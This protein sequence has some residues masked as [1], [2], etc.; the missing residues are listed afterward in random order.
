M[1][2][3]TC[4]KPIA[5]MLV[6]ALGALTAET[7]VA[8]CAAEATVADVRE[9]YAR[10]QQREQAGDAR[11]ALGAYVSAQQYTCD[12]NP[13]DAD[14]ARRAAR[15]ALPL[16]A[17]AKARGDH[18]GAFE[19]LE[20]GGHFAAAD[21]ALLAWIAAQPD[22]LA[23][24]ARARQHF[25]YRA[26]PAFQENEELRLSLL[27][28]YKVDP[29]H[30][31]LV[32][33]M[34][35]RGVERALADE[36]AA[37]DEQYLNGY[38]ELI[39]SRPEN[40]TDIAALQQFTVHA[41]AFHARHGRDALRESLQALQRAQAW[42]READPKVAAGLG[43]YRVERAASRAAL[44]TEKFADTPAL[45]ERALDYLAHGTGDTAA[46]ESALVRVRQQAEALG[47]GA[48]A[49]QSFQLAIEFYGIARADAKADRLQAQ[50]QVL[51]QQQMQ[52]SIAAM[53][54]DAT[55]LM[56]QFADPQ[57]VA[58]MKRQAL[59]AQRALQGSLMAR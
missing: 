51:A 22:D 4:T 25:S 47:D 37:F 26:L 9:A 24:Y 58:E 12:I 23:L 3:K 30:L 7:T 17:A 45:L 32:K 14:A 46:R 5:C 28:A 52:P 53:Q 31:A 13:V 10:G 16:A 36:A 33:A 8:D 21:G 41:Q 18:A 1:I 27:G 42:E 11:G 29:R 44:L 55:A 6:A 48:A 34:P 38:Q 40:T 43:K 54:R 35:V 50:R 15:L 39:R 57:K 49:K 2:M 20:M 59:E 19:I 56:A